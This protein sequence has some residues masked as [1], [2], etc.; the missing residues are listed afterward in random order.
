MATKSEAK[1]LDALRNADMKV[2]VNTERRKLN[3]PA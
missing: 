1:G 3:S 2:Y